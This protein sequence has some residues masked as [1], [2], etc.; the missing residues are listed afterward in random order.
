MVFLGHLQKIQ[1]VAGKIHDAD[2]NLSIMKD[3]ITEKEK[4]NIA[5]DFMVYLEGEKKEKILEFKEI[6]K[7]KIG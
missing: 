5:R 6:L 4:K 3:L 2:V 1:D 7:E